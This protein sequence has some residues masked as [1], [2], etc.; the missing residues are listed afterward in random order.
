MLSMPI[1]WCWGKSWHFFLQHNNSST[2][3]KRL[4]IWSTASGSSIGSIL[5]MSYPWPGE[6]QT[7]QIMTFGPLC[8]RCSRISINKHQK[9]S[10]QWETG[11]TDN[12]WIPLETIA[13][14]N[15]STPMTSFGCEEFPGIEAVAAAES[16]FTRLLVSCW[17]RMEQI[18]GETRETAQ[19]DGRFWIPG[20]SM[21]SFNQSKRLV[22]NPETY[23]S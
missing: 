10:H 1:R 16:I 15:C 3:M 13:A 4:Q 7:Q 6:Q 19:P 20:C 21:V 9:N 17:N 11:A 12:C 5:W 22:K 2:T 8:F 14:S 23:K 18:T